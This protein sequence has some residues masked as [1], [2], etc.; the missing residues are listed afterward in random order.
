MQVSLDGAALV[1]ALFGAL[2]AACTALVGAYVR[3]IHV[4]ATKDRE[5]LADLQKELAAF[6]EIVARQ[7][8]SRDEVKDDR[9][10]TREAIQR[11]EA[12]L[13]TLRTYLEQRTE[14]K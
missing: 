5:A 6:R 1:M 3:R 11:V 7:Y 2:W 12:K 9:Q 13:D 10:A 8:A 14:K 4:D